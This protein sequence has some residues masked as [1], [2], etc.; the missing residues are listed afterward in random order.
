M[1]ADQLDLVEEDNPALVPRRAQQAGSEREPLA[2][3]FARRHRRKVKK[4][5]RPDRPERAAQVGHSQR[6]AAPEP[7][8]GAGPLRAAWRG[9]T[10][11][12]LLAQPGG[13]GSLVEAARSAQRARRLAISSWLIGPLMRS[14]PTGPRAVSG[15]RR[16]W[17]AAGHELHRRP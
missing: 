17:R 16:D 2:R 11:K 14:L 7:G 15:R 10:A 9:A 1:A 4:A 3:E 5:R 6:L 8:E 13:R 12:P